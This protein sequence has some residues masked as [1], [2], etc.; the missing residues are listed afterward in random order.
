MQGSICSLL[1]AAMTL[2]ICQIQDYL[3]KTIILIFFAEQ[4]WNKQRH[5]QLKL[6]KRFH[7]N[8]CHHV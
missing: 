3:N 1:T 7:A 5:E 4:I 8:A 2:Y 6:R